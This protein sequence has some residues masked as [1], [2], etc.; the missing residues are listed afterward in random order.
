[1]LGL[2]PTGG[3]LTGAHNHW[4]ENGSI[5]CG[6]QKDMS[7]IAQL[8]FFYIKISAFTDKSSIHL[9]FI[10]L[11]ANCFIHLNATTHCDIILL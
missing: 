2:P 1:M 9:Q 5:P 7:R 3:A 4:L 10:S 11:A 6:V 8:R